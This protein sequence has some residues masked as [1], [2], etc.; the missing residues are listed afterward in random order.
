LC[1][2]RPFTVWLASDAFAVPLVLGMVRQMVLCVYVGVLSVSPSAV[3]L[4][5]ADCSAFPVPL[6]VDGRE[7]KRRGGEGRENSGKNVCGG[8]R[9]RSVLVAP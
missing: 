9:I 4:A 5:S 6:A 1:V 8:G 3:W 7:G 2:Y